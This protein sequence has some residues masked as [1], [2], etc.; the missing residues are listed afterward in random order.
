MELPQTERAAQAAA[1]PYIPDAVRS[2][3]QSCADAALVAA[4]GLPVATPPEAV[5]LMTLLPEQ[6][7]CSHL[8]WQAERAAVAASLLAWYSPQAVAP[9]LAVEEQ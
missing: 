5:R 4:A 8:L 3:A 7:A 2:A 9:A 1:E 6:A